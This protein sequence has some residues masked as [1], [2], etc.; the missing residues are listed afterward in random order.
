MEDE[1]KSRQRGRK[2][3]TEEEDSI[4]YE[5]AMKQSTTG[6][7]RDWHRIATKLPG[8][9]NKD[10]RKRWVNKVCGGLKKGLW[11]PEEDRRLQSAVEKHG[12]RWPL[13]AAEVGYRSPDQ[14]A[15]RWQYGLDPRLKHREWTPDEDKLLL[16]LVQERGREWKAIQHNHYPSRSRIDLKNRYTI[17]MRRL[18]NPNHSGQHQDAYHD[19]DG[20][21]TSSV[22]SGGDASDDGTGTTAATTVSNNSGSSSHP[23]HSR[24]GSKA[25]ASSDH[26][27]GHPHAHSQHVELDLG[28]EH[29]HVDQFEADFNAADWLDSSAFS[30]IPTTTAQHGGG[31]DP[32]SLASFLDHHSSGLRH[33]TTMLASTWDDPFSTSAAS[34][35][36]HMTGYHLSTSTYPQTSGMTTATITADDHDAGKGD[37]E[38]EGMVAFDPNLLFSDSTASESFGS[39]PISNAAGQDQALRSEQQGGADLAGVEDEDVS[40]VVIAVEGCDKDTLDYLFNVTRPIKGRVKMEITM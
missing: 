15:K 39:G 38:M 10:C 19:E 4:L 30:M 11:D 40:K 21:D 31:V 24:Q 5:E 9:T 18:N 29:Q 26:V 16:S 28:A 2:R 6:N 25:S 3:W 33:D 8:R 27:V 20:S 7:V 23:R 37:V 32:L 1:N 35:G 12:L 14:C 36:Y 22:I 34:Q 17:L 13:I